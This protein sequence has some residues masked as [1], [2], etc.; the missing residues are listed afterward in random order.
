MTDLF[1]PGDERA[2]DTFSSAVLLRAMVAVESAWLAGLVDH[3]LAPES[4][5]A[6]LTGLVDDDDRR[7]D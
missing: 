4:A 3:G 7:W 6:D 1:W 2:G 5:R